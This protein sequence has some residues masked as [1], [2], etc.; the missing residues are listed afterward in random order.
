MATI[1]PIYGG[2]PHGCWGDLPWSNCVEAF[3]L[4]AYCRTEDCPV[5][6]AGNLASVFPQ[7]VVIHVRGPEA[8]QYGICPGYFVSP[9]SGAD[10][11]FSLD[12]V[13]A[14]LR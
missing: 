7:Q 4:D 1:Y 6:E 9:M 12:R 2:E 8:R 10:A 14:H 13:R 3:E 5:F 11:K